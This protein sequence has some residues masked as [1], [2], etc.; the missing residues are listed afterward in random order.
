MYF[1]KIL[2]QVA[3]FQNATDQIVNHEPS[4]ISTKVANLRYE[5]MAEENK[6]YFTACI[7]KGK[8]EIL[9]ACVDMLY[10]L[11]GTINSNGLQELI[12]PAFNL[13][14]LNNMTKVGPDGKVLRDPN[15]KILKPEGFK[16][17]NLKQLFKDK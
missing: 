6:E 1:H 10:I 11:A 16:P 13:V 15:G 9:D 7:S 14:H 3:E 4:L 5:L 12:E 8:V 2:E 17:V